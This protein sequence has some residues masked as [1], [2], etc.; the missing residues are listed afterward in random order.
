MKG[1]IG[2]TSLRSEYGGRVDRGM[3]PEHGRKGGGAIIRKG[4]QQLEKAGFIET[5]R[6]EGRIIT[7]NGRRLLDHLSAKIKED[8]DKKNP[9]LQ[10][11]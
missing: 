2:V 7:I 1:P 8:L 3:K 6:N 4:L 5:L 11:Y 10:K 9:E